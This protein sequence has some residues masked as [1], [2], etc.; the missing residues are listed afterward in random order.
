M[1]KSYFWNTYIIRDME[2]SVSRANFC[3]CEQ[4]FAEHKQNIANLVH[5]L[6]PES[7]AIL[8]AGYLNDIPFDDLVEEGRNIYLVDW[9]DSAPRIGVSRALLSEVEEDHYNCLFCKVSAGSAFCKNFTGEFI[10]DGVCTAFEPVE[11]PFLTCKQYEPASEPRYVKADITGGVARSF[12]SK[13]E[14]QIKSCKTAKDA[15]I[16]A[17]ACADRY[18]Y[19]PIPVEDNAM[20]LVTSSMVLSQFDYE[21]YTY[22]ATL[23]EQRFARE[24]LEKHESKLLPLMEKLRSR[25]FAL[26][27]EIHTREMHR[28]VKKDG[29]ARVYLSAEL[30]RSYP[31]SDKYFLVQDMAVALETLDKYFFFSFD[32]LSGDNILRKSKLGEGVSI[33]QC[34][35]LIPKPEI[36]NNN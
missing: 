11:Q 29:K 9:L 2:Q 12:A 16:K 28:I 3:A 19:S 5:L 20:D 36:S 10:G 34:Y 1:D 8:G 27:V 22:F 26:Q 24:Q 15:F 30:F 23:L 14:K 17:I 35:C 4:A 18:H 21:P 25:L 7:I 32:E 6:A 33:N 13:I 31:D